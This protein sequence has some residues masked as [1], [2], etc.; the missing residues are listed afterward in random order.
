MSNIRWIDGNPF[1]V[2]EEKI[3]TTEEKLTPLTSIIQVPEG[4]TPQEYG[5]AGLLKDILAAGIPF[6]FITPGTK[7]AR[8]E[9]SEFVISLLY[10]GEKINERAKTEGGL[11]NRVA[12]ALSGREPVRN[13]I[14]KAQR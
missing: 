10:D 7:S 9:R 2:T 8:G 12:E 5:V 3:V 11:L 6:Q 14:N 4:M 1:L 13:T